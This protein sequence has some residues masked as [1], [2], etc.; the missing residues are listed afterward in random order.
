MSPLPSHVPGGEI[1]RDPVTGAATGI[2]IDNAMKLVEAVR[3]S[4]T[5]KQQMDYLKKMMREGV[6]R[7]LVGVHDA[8]S[9]ETSP[10]GVIRGGRLTT[11]GLG[12]LWLALV[13][14][15]E[16]GHR[17]LQ[18]VSPDASSGL[19]TSCRTC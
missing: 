13:G 19:S 8:V 10:L 1:V 5:E 11:L 6:K 12:L 14:S 16:R 4:R 17:V 2:F 7:G 3:P 15:P 9:T 18:K